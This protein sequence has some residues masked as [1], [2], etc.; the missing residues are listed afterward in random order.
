MEERKNIFDYLG[1]VFCIFGI[2]VTIL[3]VFC[4]LFGED[5]REMST[6]FQMGREGLAVVTMGQFFIVS[7]LTTTVRVLF[8]TDILIKHLSVAFRTAGMMVSTV[9][10]VILFSFLCGWF[11]IN[12]WQ[13]WVMFGLCFAASAGIS[14][15]V[16]YCRKKWKTAGWK[17]L[18]RS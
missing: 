13:P 4:I 12:M 10:I 16:A 1:E 17:R 18:W 6:L 3:C 5:A 2:T 7:V 8:F 15:A 9:L 14:T 11:P